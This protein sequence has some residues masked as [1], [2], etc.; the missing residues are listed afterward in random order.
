MDTSIAD[1]NYEWFREKL[2][3]LAKEYEGK[4]IVIKDCGVIGSYET[5][6]EAWTETLKRERA[7]TFLIQ[8]CTED[9]AQTAQTLVNLSV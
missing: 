8:L 4:Y 1:K 6:E 5:F 7:G 9:E 2:P 3:E